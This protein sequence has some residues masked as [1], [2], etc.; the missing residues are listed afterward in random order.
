MDEE[1]PDKWTKG[2]VLNLHRI[3]VASYE[4]HAINGKQ[5]LFME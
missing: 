1:W 4:I 3:T 2:F 5:F